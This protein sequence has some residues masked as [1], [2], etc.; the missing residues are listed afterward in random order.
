M[1]INHLLL[2]RLN[3]R[4]KPLAKDDVRDGLAGGSGCSLDGPA[5]APD[6]AAWLVDGPAWAADGLAWLVDA[7]VVRLVVDLLGWTDGS[8]C[9]PTASPPM[10]TASLIASAY[11][12][13]A[14]KRLVA[15]LR[16]DPPDPLPDAITRSFSAAF[17][18]F[19]A[20]AFACVT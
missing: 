5:W 9:T 2:P 1:H 14:S 3:P 6:G 7:L 13:A 8:P 16:R 20:S 12:A 10:L 11:I 19:L 17:A 15:V 4:S 18:A